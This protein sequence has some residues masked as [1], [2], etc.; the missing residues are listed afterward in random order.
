MDSAT[1]QGVQRIINLRALLLSSTF[2]NDGVASILGQLPSLI[3]IDLRNTK[4]TE[5]GKQRIRRMTWL[6]GLAL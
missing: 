1:L 4:L 2:V 3:T 6:K 5:A